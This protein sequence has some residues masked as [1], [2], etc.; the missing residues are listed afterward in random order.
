VGSDVVARAGAGYTA[1]RG[2]PSFLLGTP[3]ETPDDQVGL[4]RPDSDADQW[5]QAIAA[6]EGDSPHGRRERRL[7]VTGA[8]PWAVDAAFC[9]AEA[10]GTV[11]LLGPGPWTLSGS[12][13]LP[14]RCRLFTVAR[15]H[16]DFVPEALAAL[17]R[18]EIGP[19][20]ALLASVRLLG[21]A[22]TLL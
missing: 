5:R 19:R 17:R 15:Y 18:D 1:R 6:G 7:F 21:S 20:S 10:G 2:C 4:L 8:G 13:P 22:R 9:L 16:P 12:L 11:T 3:P 14:E